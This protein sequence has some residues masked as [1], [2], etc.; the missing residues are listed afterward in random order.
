M[1]M[2]IDLYLFA[3]LRQNCYLLQVHFQWKYLIGNTISTVLRSL[4]STCFHLTNFGRYQPRP[5][6]NPT[7]IRNL[8]VN[9]TLNAQLCIDFGIVA[10]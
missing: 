3:I 1:L 8:S 10:V 7:Q 6:P 2:M 4:N 9:V 5:N